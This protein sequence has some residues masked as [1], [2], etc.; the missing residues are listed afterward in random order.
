[1]NSWELDDVS[2]RILKYNG[3]LFDLNIL[4]DYGSLFNKYSLEFLQKWAIDYARTLEA[5]TF[6]CG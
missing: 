2:L 6:Y 5:E 1:M 3:G 4:C